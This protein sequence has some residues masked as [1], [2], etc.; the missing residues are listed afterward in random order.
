MGSLIFY[1]T[2]GQALKNKSWD[3]DGSIGKNTCWATMKT[4]IWIPP[5]TWQVVCDLPCLSL[6]NWERPRVV[7]E[8]KGL[9]VCQSSQ[10]F[11]SCR[12]RGTLFQGNNVGS[13][14]RHLLSP[15]PLTHVCAHMCESTCTHLHTQM[16]KTA[17]ALPQVWLDLFFLSHNS[18]TGTVIF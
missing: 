8:L 14:S 12:F 1:F 16:K 9:V 7:G 17:V 5:P 13:D 15:D 11:M 18:F 10:K 3:G 2:C 6:Q 4:R